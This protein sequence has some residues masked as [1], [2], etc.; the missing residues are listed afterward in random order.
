MRVLTPLKQVRALGS[1]K[2]GTSH[3]FRSRTTGLALCLL[4]PP[5][6]AILIGLQGASHARLLATLAN[7]LVAVTMLLAVA[8][9]A[10]HMKLGMQVIIEDYVHDEAW[11]LAALIANAFFSWTLGAAGLFAILRMAL[12]A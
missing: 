11:K 3:F 8:V 10:C 7:P 5:F 1:A 6:L 9:S 4:I 2:S 12:R